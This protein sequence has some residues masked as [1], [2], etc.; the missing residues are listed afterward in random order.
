MG[1][2]QGTPGARAAEVSL[3]SWLKTDSFCITSSLRSNPERQ[4][5]GAALRQH[6][7]HPPHVENYPG[8]RKSTD[9]W[10]WANGLS[11]GIGAGKEQY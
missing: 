8:A 10:T 1:P 6:T 4:Q 3:T 5:G 2:G 11:Y 7:G 9:A